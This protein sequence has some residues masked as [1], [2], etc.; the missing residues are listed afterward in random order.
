MVAPRSSGLLGMQLS[1]HRD[2]QCY[3]CSGGITDLNPE[4][5][6]LTEEDGKTK[7]NRQSYVMQSP[8]THKSYNLL[9]RS[10]EAKHD[11]LQ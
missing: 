8:V 2:K 1:K 11:F 4:A 10:S 5:T 3:M 9:Y 7:T 6:C